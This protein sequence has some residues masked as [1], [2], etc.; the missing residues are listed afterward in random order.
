M[1]GDKAFI[2]SFYFVSALNP[3]NVSWILEEQLMVTP[4]ILTMKMISG[5][6]K[7]NLA[8]ENEQSAS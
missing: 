1:V 3:K 7:V 8:I 5:K 2:F 4:I 6:V